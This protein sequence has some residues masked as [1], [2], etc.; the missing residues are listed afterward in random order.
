[1]STALGTPEVGVTVAPGSVVVTTTAGAD[2]QSGA[3]QLVS[4]LTD[5]A[6]DA[7]LLSEL[8]GAPA[9]VDLESVTIT[10]NPDAAMPPPPPPAKS[11]EDHTLLA[12]LIILAILVPT[13][14]FL[15]YLRVDSSAPARPKGRSKPYRPIANTTDFPI[16]RKGGRVSF[17]FDM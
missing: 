5:M 8:Y 16:S 1:M 9:E 6:G 7:D 14:A 3:D 17:K 2:D 11:E 12:I 10:Q 13:A 15:L 4:E